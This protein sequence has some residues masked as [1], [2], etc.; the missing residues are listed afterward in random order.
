MEPVLPQLREVDRRHGDGVQGSRWIR[1]RPPE[2][3]KT[4][5]HEHRW[6]RIIAAVRKV[7]KAPLTYAANW[8]DY[9]RVGFWDD[10]DIIGIQAYFPVSDKKSASVAELH[11][12]WARTMATLRPA[13]PHASGATSCSR[14][15][16]TTTRSTPRSNRGSRRATVVPR[17]HTS[18]G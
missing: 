8:T 16:A 13:S 12:G 2:L 14:S 5:R 4:L 9:Q 3:D 6:R 7:T 15:S 11:A 18:A 10:L 17:T 1:G